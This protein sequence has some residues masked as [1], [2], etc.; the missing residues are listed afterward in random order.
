MGRY[1]S[2]IRRIK[3]TLDMIKFEHSV[4][5]LPFAFMGAFL[6]ERGIPHWDKLLWILIA[7]IS[8]RS[9][10]MAFNRL[11]DR[12]IDAINPRTRQRALPSGKVS[13]TWVRGFIIFW[14]VV[15]VFSSY[16]LNRLVF[17]LSPVALAIVMVYSYA[18]RFTWFTHIFL[19]IADGIA[20]LAGWLA[21]K[22][23]IEATPLCLFA[24]VAFWVAG[25]DILYG[26]L[27]YD[28]DRKEGIYSIPA[29]F[30]IKNALYISI[31]FHMLTIICFFAVGVAARLTPVYFY[32]MVF[33][34]LLLLGEHLIIKPHDFSRINMAFFTINGFIGIAMFLLIALP[35]IPVWG[36]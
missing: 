30:G 2:V 27:D 19:G 12:E 25:F 32:G 17:C 35:I 9:V 28:F 13:P 16:N 14:A 24:G 10:A 11:V 23:A 18:K 31:F 8:A 36:R 6:A 29:R 3:T 4:F 22:P 21:I 7:M 33:V 5:A 15:F 1:L 26:C 34:S 20:P